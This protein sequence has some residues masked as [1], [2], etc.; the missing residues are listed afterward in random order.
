MRATSEGVDWRPVPV[1]VT[2]WGPRIG[3]LLAVVSEHSE[4]ILKI[5]LGPDCDLIRRAFAG[6]WHYDMTRGG[7]VERDTPAKSE[8][9][10]ADFGDA[11]CYAIEE[12]A[13]SRKPKPRSWKPNPS[14]T[15]FSLVSMTERGR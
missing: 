15:A 4:V 5:D 12:I 1:C 11:A 3:P 8:R 14:R 9:L 2:Y 7:T 6:M 10:F 13:P